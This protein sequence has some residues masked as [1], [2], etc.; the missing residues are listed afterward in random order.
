M[1]ANQEE[2]IQYTSLREHRI[3]L[4]QIE[5][6]LR[7]LISSDPLLSEIQP[8]LTACTEPNYNRLVSEHLD[9]LVDAHHGRVLQLELKFLD[10]QTCPIHVS[11]TVNFAQLRKSIERSLSLRAEVESKARV[12]LYKRLDWNRLW[13]K[14]DLWI[15]RTQRIRFSPQANTDDEILGLGHQISDSILVNHSVIEFIPQR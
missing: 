3:F 10:G 8:I 13:N 1:M 11:P 15:D 12:K 14:Y 2:D 7:S 9:C 6:E 4:N 5:S